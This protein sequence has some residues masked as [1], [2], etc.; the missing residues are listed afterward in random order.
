MDLSLSTRL[1]ERIS[2]LARR[3][4]CSPLVLIHKAIEEFLERYEHEN[5]VLPIPNPNTYE[6]Q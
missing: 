5:P 1:A 6:P 4:G 3:T 2:A